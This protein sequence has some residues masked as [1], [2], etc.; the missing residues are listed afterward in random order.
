MKIN[1]SLIPKKAIVAVALSGGRDSMALLHR[2]VEENINVKAI[3]VEH[4][5]RGEVSKEEAKGVK[6]YCDKIGVECRT[7]EVDAIKY[8][9]EKKLTVE[10]SARELRYSCFENALEEGF[11]DLVATAHHADDN[12]ETVI[13][14]L[15]RG[16]GIKGLTG[17]SDRRD[18]YI[19]P[20]LETTREEIDEYVKKNNIVYFE[21]ETNACLDY[22]RNFVRH[23]ILERIKERFPSVVKSISRL[24]TLAKEDEEYFDKI[25][26]DKIVDLKDA[27][28]IKIE[29][30]NIT[31][32]GE[33]LIRRA[34]FNLGVTADVEERHI[35]LVKGLKDAENGT[36]L[37]MPYDTVCTKEY[38]TIAIYKRRE[39]IDFEYTVSKSATYQCGDR[40][41]HVEEVDKRGREGLFVD[42]DKIEGATIRKKREG[43]IFKRFGGGTKSL[44]DYLT[45]I[46]M[47]V[48]LRENLVV[49]AKDREVL[50]V[51]GVEISDKVK[52]DESTV[53][54]GKIGEDR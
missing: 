12:A 35:D 30:L 28:G 41:V 18:R 17:I 43:D 36:S 16:T 3:C 42:L 37:D 25:V 51:V 27:F 20:L 21:D 52:V 22:T 19:R 23:D 14:R 49:I 9:K 50:V 53:R 26:E 48:R 44:G 33:R 54:I 10:Q 47:P 34:F 38:D 46:K 5:I 13:I 39:D 4:G 31:A 1:L 11:C 7:Y 2:L 40:L 29:D 32:V 8:S 24:S 15:I 45:D 6:S